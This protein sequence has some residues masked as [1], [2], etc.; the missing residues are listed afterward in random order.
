MP[1]SPDPVLLLFGKS[2]MALVELLEQNP[3]FGPVEQM[4]IENHLHILH[5][6]YYSWKRRQNPE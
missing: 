1:E 4:L 5:M 2:S 6:A 3:S